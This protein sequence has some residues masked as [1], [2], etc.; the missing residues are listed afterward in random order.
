V[1]LEEGRLVEGERFAFDVFL[2]GPFIDAA[3]AVVASF[4]GAESRGIG[5]RTSTFNLGEV[6]SLDQD[7]LP[8]AAVPHREVLSGAAELP[9]F[10]ISPLTSEVPANQSTSAE[11]GV[12]FLTPTAIKHSGHI[13]RVPSFP[14]LIDAIGSR[15]RN[16][17][18][19]WGPADLPRPGWPRAAERVSLA[20][21]M[22]T[23]EERRI[24]SAH[25][26]GT[27]YLLDGFVGEARY[28]GPV[29]GFLPWLR[30]GEL[31]HV[32]R[33]TNFGCGWLYL[34]DGDLER[35]R[36]VAWLDSRPLPPAPLRSA[37][38]RSTPSERGYLREQGGRNPAM[39][40]EKGSVL[41]F[42]TKHAAPRATRR[43]EQMLAAKT[44]PV[45]ETAHLVVIVPLRDIDTT[46]ETYR[47]RASLD[48]PELERSLREQGQK[49]PVFLQRSAPGQRLRI[50]AG[51]CRIHALSALARGHVQAVV[52][53]ADD[54]DATRIAWAENA[55]RRSLKE[56]DL[57]YLVWRLQH[58]G[59]NLAEIASTLGVSTSQ[60]R[61]LE[62]I[63]AMPERVRE[64]VDASQLPFT[65]AAVLGQHLKRHPR[66]D[67]E[68]VLAAWKRTPWEAGRFAT[69]LERA[70]GAIGRG[71]RPGGVRVR[72]EIVQVDRRHFDPTALDAKRQRELREFARWLMERL[73]DE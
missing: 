24:A 13:D 14:A 39:M 31:L 17:V 10:Q 30:L 70:V 68:S 21:S 53:E 4:A 9:W 26:P 37:G 19:R 62:A 34:L 54:P 65:H 44:H 60:V 12:R 49:V 3:P 57:V 59:R 38:L 2:V 7:G 25:Q 56:V 35:F 28:H 16:L 45:Y 1:P 20:S 67:P 41:P 50:V 71:R 23:W 42:G 52:L 69:E 40:D 11:V 72:G 8:L 33:K 64:L 73:G 32:G 55:G 51:F 63:G 22:G 58:D 43:K 66:H 48:N 46:D 29:A 27:E 18:E 15:F 5:R 61:R 36:R 6:Q 47:Q